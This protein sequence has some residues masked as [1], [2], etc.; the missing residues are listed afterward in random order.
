MTLNFDN[1]VNA[2]LESSA[3]KKKASKKKSRDYKFDSRSGKYYKPKPVEE[4]ERIHPSQ[5]GE[6]ERHLDHKKRLAKRDPS[7]KDTPAHLQ[8]KR[9][10]VPT[11]RAYYGPEVKGKRI[12]PAQ[13]SQDE[14]AADW[15]KRQ[16][17]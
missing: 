7:G 14:R 3:C 13:V 16:R 12:H 5:V 9:V 4:G 11:S 2:L 8:T 6:Y 17:K 1:L 10:Q 15:N